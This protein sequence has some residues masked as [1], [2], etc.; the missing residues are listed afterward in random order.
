MVRIV[1]M[2]YASKA[3]SVHLRSLCSL[4]FQTFGSLLLSSNTIKKTT[5]TDGHFN[6]ADSRNRTDTGL[7]PTD[8]K[9][10]VSTSST[11]SA[12]P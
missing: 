3:C 2:S 1:G 4:R 12:Q 8:F 9:S 5:L 11:I 7:L 10:V 6:G